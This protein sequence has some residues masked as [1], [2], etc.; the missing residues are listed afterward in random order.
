MK[1]HYSNEELVEIIKQFSVEYGRTPKISE[2][3]VSK[4]T[5]RLRFGSFSNAIK[6]AG[7]QPNRRDEKDLE[8]E[9]VCGTIFKAYSKTQKF[10]SHSCHATTT[11]SLK[12]YRKRK[13][14]KRCDV[15]GKEHSNIRYC[16]RVCQKADT[17]NKFKAGL[18]KSRPTLFK[19]INV[20]SCMLC[21]A[22]EWLGHP[23]PLEVDHI[24]GDASNNSPDNLRIICPNCHSITATWKGRNKGK[25]RKSRGISTY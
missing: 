6:L 7:L 22:A 12:L 8:K 19:Q 2:L 10:C 15:C 17:A 18:V 11:N 9:C 13:I 21:G 5:Y 20:N 16:S 25:G 23:L 14:L 3:C 4:E 1:K 24:D